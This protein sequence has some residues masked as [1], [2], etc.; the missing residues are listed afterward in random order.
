L[1]AFALSTQVRTPRPRQAKRKVEQPLRGLA[2]D[3]Q[4]L[5][6]FAL[7][8]HA[9]AHGSE[10]P[11]GRFADHDEIDAALGRA[12][13]RARH[14]GDQPAWPHAGI[15]IEDEAQLDLRHDLGIVGIADVRQPARAEQ[16]RVGFL[17]QLHGRFRHRLA[18]VAIVSGARRRLGEAEFEARR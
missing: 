4:R 18:G 5:A 1:N 7:G 8:Y 17:A 10:Q 9:L 16:D 14:V 12:H 15:E 13:D 6:R 11:L 3:E 2:R